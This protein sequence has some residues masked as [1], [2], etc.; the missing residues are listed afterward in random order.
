MSWFRVVL[1]LILTAILSATTEAQTSSRFNAKWMDPTCKPCEDFYRFV[2]GT[3]LKETPI[4]PAYSRWGTFQIRTEDNLMLLREILENAAK[5][6]AAPGKN[7]QMIGSFYASCVDEPRIET[8]GS[9]PIAGDLARIDRIDDPKSF[10]DEIARLHGLGVP[11]VFYFFANHDLKNS[12]QN[13]A[14]V[15]QG[16]LSL[17]NRDYYAKT[18]DKS[19]Q[20][21]A[22][23][24]KHVARMFELLGDA[25]EKA[26]KGADAIL[27]LESQLAE[28]SMAPAELRDP[29][30]LDNKRSMAQLATLTPEFSW[31]NYV[32]ERGVRKLS[33]I[34]VA[35][36]KF[37]EGVNRLL[38]SV[39]LA[40]WKT[41]LRWQ[42]IRNAAPRLST[43][44]VNEDF[45]FYGRTLTGTKELLPR[46][47]RCVAATDRL[48][49][50]ALGQAYVAKQFPPEAR[51][52]VDAMIDNL[53]RAF[54]ERIQSLDWMSDTTKRQAL[55]KLE[56]FTRKIGYP[57][58]WKD[59]SSLR[60][61]RDRYFTNYRQ[62]DALEI[63]RDV[64]KIGK[65]VDKTEWTMTPPTVNAYYNPANNEIVFP[66]GILQPP[67]FDSQADDALNYG[68]IGAVIGHEV[69]H[70]FD[71]QG[72]QYD[73]EGNLRTWWLPEDRNKFMT[74]SDCVSEQFGSYQ[75]SDGLNLNGKLVLGESIADLGGLTI[76]YQAFLKSMEG[77]PRPANIDGFTPDQRFFIGWATVWANNQRVESERQQTLSDGHP[78][79]RYRVNGPLSNLAAFAAAFGCKAGEPMVR[80]PERRCQVW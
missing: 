1:A 72:S 20:L 65:P 28:V 68:A 5:N 73:P 24:V 43:K 76:A 30:A 60:L 6:D 3:W 80:P 27:N 32:S 17:P 23:F 22:D 48:L 38:K 49:G 19:K 47:R 11:A 78:L 21:R 25:P 37:F 8:L 71:D 2:T 35:Q 40:D 56:A 15:Y 58:R 57:A 66:A 62:G 7:E 41:Y 18:D 75:T 36:P 54:R 59:Y 44:F 55:L 53:V 33:E 52:R 12:S 64:A 67:F 13:I 61:A 46:W 69:T 14:W 70:G 10:E 74:R 29:A 31:T 77:K 16:G 51:A 45:D 34:N 79:S 4:P 42:V 39:P 26:S 63:K 9:R 50:E